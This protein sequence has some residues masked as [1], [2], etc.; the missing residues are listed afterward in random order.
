MGYPAF[1][2]LGASVSANE[3]DMDYKDLKMRFQ[4]IRPGGVAGERLIVK[5]LKEAKQHLG[6][7]TDD[8]DY[9]Q[10]PFVNKAPIA[11]KLAIGNAGF[12]TT[13]SNEIV[14][15]VWSNP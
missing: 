6:A 5:Q 1:G 2:A 7:D 8:E 9:T 3:F 14:Q 10:T 12:Y 13:K 15:S 4:R 11:R